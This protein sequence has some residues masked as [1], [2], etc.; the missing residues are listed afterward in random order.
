M[1]YDLEM[2]SITG[3]KVAFSQC[4]DSVCLAV[5]VASF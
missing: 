3:A 4:A 5:N 2:T 1:F